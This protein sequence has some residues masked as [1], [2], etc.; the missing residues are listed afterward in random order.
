MPQGER[1]RFS[2]CILHLLHAPE[3][4]SAGGISE[5]YG[6]LLDNRSAG[7]VYLLPLN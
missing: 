5:I 7:V 2:T 6:L 3:K 1:T 4:G